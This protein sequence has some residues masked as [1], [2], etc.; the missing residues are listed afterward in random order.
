MY[1]ISISECELKAVWNTS[2]LACRNSLCR[3]IKS[4]QS[5]L[6]YSY[7]ATY[8]VRLDPDLDPD[9]LLGGRLRRTLFFWKFE[10]FQD[11][12]NGYTS[13]LS[14]AT[15]PTSLYITS[16]TANNFWIK[17]IIVLECLYGT[18]NDGFTGK[19]GVQILK[20]ISQ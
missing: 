13:D 4:Q 1:A 20:I 5:P 19:V 2:I 11:Q 17:I 15:N 14:F 6:S 8:R 16:L 12:Q 9:L 10:K 18:Q 7:N 3:I